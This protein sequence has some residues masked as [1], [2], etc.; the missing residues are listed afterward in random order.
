MNNDGT[1]SFTVWDGP[2]GR[3]R[4]ENLAAASHVKG[5]LSMANYGPNTNGAPRATA[6]PPALATSS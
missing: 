1:G 3:F 2:S 5:T 6:P 4:D